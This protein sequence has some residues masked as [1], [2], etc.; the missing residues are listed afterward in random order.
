MLTVD[1]KLSDPS[2]VK[3]YIENCFTSII[4][5][6]CKQIDCLHLNFFQADK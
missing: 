4:F 5:L 2:F 1:T 6:N 3:V